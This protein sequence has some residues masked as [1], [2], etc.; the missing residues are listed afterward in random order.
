MW[1]AELA[2]GADETVTDFLAIR[3][4]WEAALFKRYEAQI[5]DAWEAA[6]AAHALP[7]EPNAD[8]TID[9]I[10]QDAA[11]RAAQRGLAEML[12]ASGPGARHSPGHA[13]GILH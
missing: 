3:L 11:E 6:V 4:V 7:V 5:G 9:A 12:A 13:G 2:G 10:L 8:Q 1:Q